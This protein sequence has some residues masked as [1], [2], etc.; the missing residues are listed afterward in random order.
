MKKSNLALIASFVLRT[1]SLLRGGLPI[2]RALEILSQESGE[3]SDIAARVLARAQKGGT[4]ADSFACEPNEAWR[5]FGSALEIATVSGAP[6]SEVCEKM[7]HAFLKLESLEQRRRVIL[8]APKATIILL[9]FLPLIAIFFGEL[10]GLKILQELISPLGLILLVIGGLLLTIGIGW[11]RVQIKKV[12]EAD[13]VAGIEM[14]LMWVALAGGQNILQSFLLVADSADR[15][16]S[17]WIRLDNLNQNSKLGIALA[18]AQLSGSPVRPQISVE[19]QIERE[20]AHS[21][22]EEEAEKLSIKILLPIG[23]CILPAFVVMGIVP[24]V[25]SMLR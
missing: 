8:A 14:D 24:I 18:T 21:K 19:A 4:I 17:N 23:L 7:S 3:M 6:F 12:A 9:S 20:Q 15:L 22:L 1:A 13:R 16:S 25:L 5:V 2:M 11:A 10:L